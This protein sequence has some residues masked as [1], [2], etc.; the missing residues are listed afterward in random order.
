MNYALDPFTVQVTESCTDSV[1]YK[2][3]TAPPQVT[4]FCARMSRFLGADE[5]VN[6]KSA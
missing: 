4:R 3:P 6:R 2:Q 1:H 5:E